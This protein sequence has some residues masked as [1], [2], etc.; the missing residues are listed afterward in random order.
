MHWDD[1]LYI[2]PA[3]VAQPAVDTAR[4]VAALPIAV[5]AAL[6]GWFLYLAGAGLS[7]WFDADDLMNLHYYWTRPWSAFLKGTLAFWSTFYR[8]TGGLFYRALY[9]M[10]G[11][12]PLPFHVVL[13]ALLSIDFAL[14]AIVVW[15][16]T[17]SRWGVLIVLLLLGGNPAFAPAFF[18]G[19]NIYD[20]LAYTFFWGGFALY[21]RFRQNGRPLSYGQL[22]L[23]C[24]FLVAA[25]DSKEIA[26]S[27]PVAVGL[28]ELLWHPPANRHVRELR[29]W[30]WSEGRYALAGAL[31][32]AIYIIGKRYGAESLWQLG[33]YRPQVST[34]AYLRSLAFYLDRL[35]YAPVKLSPWLV[36][37]LL[38]AALVLGIAARRRCLVWAAGFIAVS[39]LPL[40]FIA[41]RGGTSYFVPSVGWAVLIAGFLEWLVRSLTGRRVWLRRTLQALLFA[42]LAVILIPWQQKWMTIDANADHAEQQRF[43]TYIEQIHALIP[44]PRK[45]AHILLLSD[46]RERDEF[47]MVFL[48]CLYYGDRELV[49][50]RMTVWKSHGVQVD[51]HAY[52]YVLDWEDNRFVLVR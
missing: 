41:P 48:L 37:A 9:A 19:G 39:I 27:L 4:L 7:S 30:I 33:P 40:S 1:H 20:T 50:H 44:A 12:H 14:L 6:F 42:T 32:V 17:K 36:P 49:V 24:G 23:L 15:Q 16:L 10:W 31:L 5:G 34:G 29:R 11:F 38:A 22:A 25:L 8:P 47:D 52:D 45:G 3:R 35:I 28:Y 46:V 18:E 2:P 13:L 43:R 51:E 21:V 26:V